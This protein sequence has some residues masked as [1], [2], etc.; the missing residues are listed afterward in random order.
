M[1]DAELRALRASVY[2]ECSDEN[3][4]AVRENWRKV[5][6]ISFLKERSAAMDLFSSKPKT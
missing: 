3:W 4:K 5:D 2:G 6:G 1:S